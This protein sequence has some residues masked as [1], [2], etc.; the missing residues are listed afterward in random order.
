M[1]DKRLVKLYAEMS[2]L[3]SP[4]CACTCRV[5][6]SCCSP[7]YCDLAIEW[8]KKRWR[9]ELPRSNGKSARGETLPLMGPNGCIAEPHFRPICTIHTCQVN[10]LGF[11]PGD[12]KWTAKYFRLR[13]KIE[14]LEYWDDL[15]TM[16]KG[17]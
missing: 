5:P 12:P 6:H 16:E 8:A 1:N 14:S 9:V 15:D 17:L 2:K 3:T 7:E 13:E 11:K 10:G 4:E